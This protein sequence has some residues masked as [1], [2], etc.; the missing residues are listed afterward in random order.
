MATMYWRIATRKRGAAPGWDIGLQAMPRNEAELRAAAFNG[1]YAGYEHRAVFVPP[2]GY[3]QRDWKVYDLVKAWD[4]AHFEY[5]Q[6]ERVRRSGQSWTTHFA[7]RDG[8]VVQRSHKTGGPPIEVPP[9]S[10][11]LG[12]D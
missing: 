8:Q 5:W 10:P 11:E 6:R 4:Q 12:K 3:E 9:G 1:L 2:E 7:K